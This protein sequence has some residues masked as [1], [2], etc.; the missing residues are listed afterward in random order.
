MNKQ[1][2]ILSLALCLGFTTLTACGPGPGDPMSALPNQAA[3]QPTNTNSELARKS[4]TALTSHHQ[5]DA[6]LADSQQLR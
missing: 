5:V 4:Q 6:N 2:L 3:V 1:T